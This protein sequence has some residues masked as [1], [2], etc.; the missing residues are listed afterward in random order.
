MSER[1]GGCAEALRVVAL[2]VLVVGLVVLIGL[3]IIVYGDAHEKRSAAIDTQAREK[4]AQTEIAWNGIT[5]RTATEEEGKTKRTAIEEEGKTER[6]LNQL[7]HEKF[8]LIWAEQSWEQRLVMLA[9]I[10]RGM[11]SEE[12]QALLHMMNAYEAGNTAEDRNWT[13]IFAWA[14]AIFGA[15]LVFWFLGRPLLKRVFISMPWGW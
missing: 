14:W 13:Q 8:L 9:E 15:I 1:L 2:I 10:T 6:Q 7:N 12:R 11:T 5:E 4:T 3:G